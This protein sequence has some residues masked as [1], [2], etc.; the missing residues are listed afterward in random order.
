MIFLFLSSEIMILGLFLP[1]S[2]MLFCWGYVLFYFLCIPLLVKNAFASKHSSPNS[3]LSFCFI[4]GQE[5]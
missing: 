3:S 1:L 5:G 2:V 4:R